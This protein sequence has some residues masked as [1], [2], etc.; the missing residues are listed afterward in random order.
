MTEK[1]DAVLAALATIGPMTSYEVRLQLGMSKDAATDA[2]R[3]LK[4]KGMVRI[5]GYEA[6]GSGAGR[7]LPVYGG[8]T[9]TDAKQPQ[10]MPIDHTFSAMLRLQKNKAYGIWAGVVR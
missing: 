7:K 10:D 6:D 1:Q 2:I 8:G 4:D 5:V 3:R 9:G